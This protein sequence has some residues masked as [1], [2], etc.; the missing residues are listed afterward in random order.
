MDSL[1]VC[2][3]LNMDTILTVDYLPLEGQ[4]TPV[5]SVRKEYGG[6]GG[7]IS[8]A[9]AKLGVPVIL[10]SVVGKDFYQG[11]RRNLEALGIDLEHIVVIEEEPSPFCTVLSAPEGKQ[12]YAFMEG[13]MR[14]QEDLPPPMPLGGSVAYCHIATSHPKFTCRTSRSMRKNGVEA[15]FDPGQEIYFRW[16]GEE[17]RE[18]LSNCT[19]FMGNLGEWEYL[20][21]L[22]D[23]QWEERKISDIVYPWSERM[24]GMIDEAVVT[25][26]SK[27][28]ILI[29][30]D[31]T[32][33]EPA[34]EVPEI[35]DATGAGDAFRGGFYGALLRGIAPEDALLYG[36]AMG[37]LSITSMGPQGYLASWDQLMELIEK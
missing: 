14:L 33:H 25:A 21:D 8:T 22:L 34:F 16:R 28:S 31:D 7:N 13:A 4:S 9:A 23:V 26:G 17:A 10:S 35:L 29:R 2:G 30:R 32:S 3:N 1:L 6:C 15:A 12:C 36:N 5:R 37:A 19:R 11:Y 24:F 18:V 20:M 27:G